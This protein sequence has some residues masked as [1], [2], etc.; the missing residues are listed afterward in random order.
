[1]PREAAWRAARSRTRDRT[2]A[3]PGEWTSRTAN[4]LASPGGSSARLGRGIA[5]ELKQSGKLA[6]FEV[7]SELGRGGMGA[8]LEVRYRGKPYALKLLLDDS[9][10]IRK[11][12]AREAQILGQLDH[13]GIVTLR[14]AGEVDG[15][16][17]LLH[18]LVP[19]ARP[20]S[21]A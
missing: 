21:A 7:Q 6:P 20:L 12:M 16:A 3:S 17:F 19:R 5:E 4:A 18:D 1:M 15:R 8:V 14:G 10:R 11:R 9:Q 2:C 13:P